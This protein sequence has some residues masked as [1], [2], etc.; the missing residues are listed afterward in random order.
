MSFKHF[1]K[2]VILNSWVLSVILGV[3]V[4]ILIPFRSEQFT[5]EVSNFN[6]YNEG[7]QV[8]IADLNSDGLDEVVVVSYNKNDIRSSRLVLRNNNKT[9]EQY[10][11]Y[12]VHSTSK[13]ASTIDDYDGDGFSEIYTTEFDDST[14]FVN[15]DVPFQDTLDWS[16]HGKKIPIERFKPTENLWAQ[17][18]VPDIVLQDLNNDNSK[19]IILSLYGRFENATTRRLIAYDIV[20]EEINKSEAFGNILADILFIDVNGDGLPE[21][22]GTCGSSNNVK[23]DE[24][25]LYRDD[26]AYLFVFD[27]KLNLINEPPSYYGPYTHIGIVPFKYQQNQEIVG[28]LNHNGRQDIP[29]SIFVSKDLES[30]QIVDSIGSKYPLAGETSAVMHSGSE[31]YLILGS[32]DGH[33]FIYNRRIKMIHQLHLGFPISP[34]IFICDLTQNGNEEAVVVHKSQ[35]EMTIFN[36]KA[37][38]L[39]TVDLED[40]DDGLVSSVGIYNGFNGYYG[41]VHKGRTIYFLKFSRNYFY[42]GK[43]GILLLVIGLFLGL[44]EFVKWTQ[45]R[46]I[47]E[48]IDLA[49]QVKNLQLQSAKNQLN[50]HFTFNALNVLSYFSKQNDNQGVERFTHHFS[51]LLRQQVELSDQTYTTLY[52]ET[53]FIEHYVELQKLRYDVPVHFDLEV[54]SGI[55][56]NLK[57]PKM[58]IHTHVENAIKHGLIPAGGGKILVRIYPEKSKTIID[59]EDN[60]AGR[61]INLADFNNRPGGSTNKGLAIL[62]Q[63]YDLFYQLY[64][65]RI[66]QKIIDLKDK[67]GNPTGTRV[68]ISVL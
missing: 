55:D 52:K 29:N 46:Q 42:Y 40:F 14:L 19:E 68:S 12:R 47:Q 24:S 32:P 66:D 13:R 21:I 30:Y 38:V 33:I 23:E 4:F 25:V 39:S 64:K 56:M 63:L 67:D 36:A 18:E 3:I 41:Y 44:I 34:L 2:D 58:M 16:L 11:S 43:W 50:P 20:N 61:K 54:E 6:V 49:N 53:Q 1:V 65:V 26:K 17:F 27:N 5:Y 31:E 10:N 37:K 7:D 22:L 45:R 57:V 9:W 59:I 8:I 35:S 60:G 28:I 62:D 48:K 51:K 15:I